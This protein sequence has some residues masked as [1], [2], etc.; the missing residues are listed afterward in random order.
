MGKSASY[1][2]KEK[3]LERLDR[4]SRNHATLKL[5]LI[6]SLNVPCQSLSGLLSLVSE[7]RYVHVHILSSLQFI[8]FLYTAKCSFYRA[9]N[10]IIIWQIR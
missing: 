8:V 3:E 5:V 7:L 4:P 1:E 9:T 2:Q 6:M 10:S